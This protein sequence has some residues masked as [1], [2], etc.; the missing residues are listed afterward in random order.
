MSAIYPAIVLLAERILQ[1]HSTMKGRRPTAKWLRFPG[2]PGPAAAHGLATETEP[3][4][5]SPPVAQIRW[6]RTVRIVIV[7]GKYRFPGVL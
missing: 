3:P 6:H 2:R 1:A 5:V 7:A 4:Q